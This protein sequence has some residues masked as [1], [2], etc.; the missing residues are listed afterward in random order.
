MKH[1]HYDVMMEWAADT[2]KVVQFKNC[3][4]RWEN[5]AGIPWWDCDEYRIKPMPKPDVVLT[6]RVEH[7]VNAMFKPYPVFFLDDP[8]SNLRL[9]FSGED[10][11]L[12]K[13]EVL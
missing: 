12:I 7:G 2:N 4:G 8:E 11:R 1:K 6:V 3:D 13:A 5:V 9:T 10:G